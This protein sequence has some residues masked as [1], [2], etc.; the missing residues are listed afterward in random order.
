MS[1][2]YKVTNTTALR[3][4]HRGSL[5]SREVW[6]DARRVLLPGESMVL[7]ELPG[8]VAEMATPPDALTGKL[9]VEEVD[10]ET[11]EPVAGPAVEAVAEPVVEEAPV[12]EETAEVAVEEVVSPPSAEDPSTPEVEVAEEESK[13]EPSRRRGSGKQTTKRS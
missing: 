13:P 4:D 8:G 5:E 7:E 3:P 9:S 2:A 6:V 1:L 10:A 11:G 12:A